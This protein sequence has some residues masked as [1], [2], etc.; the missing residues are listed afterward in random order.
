MEKNEWNRMSV[1]LLKLK[2]GEDLIAN[3]EKEN[4]EFITVSNP[5]VLMPMSDGRGNAV[6]MGLVP[7]VPFSEAK[8]FEIPREW[9]VLITTP[10][11]NVVNN[12][13]QAYGAGIVVPTMSQQALLQ[14]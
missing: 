5:A 2:S 7:W 1:T 3:L 14:E 11:P 12:Y 8:E 9:V 10:A 6:Q 13:N 4:A